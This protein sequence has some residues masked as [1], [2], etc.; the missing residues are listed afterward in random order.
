MPAF[1]DQVPLGMPL[2]VD[3]TIVRIIVDYSNDDTMHPE[4]NVAP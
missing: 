1:V 2:C 4:P 3:D